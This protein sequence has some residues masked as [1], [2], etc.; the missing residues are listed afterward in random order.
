MANEQ[1]MWEPTTPGRRIFAQRTVLRKLTL[2]EAVA[3]IREQGALIDAG[4]LSK[5][6][7]DKERPNIYQAVA[8]AKFY[9]VRLND[10]G[11]SLSRDYP[12]A[13]SFLKADTQELLRQSGWSRNP[14]SDLLVSGV[15]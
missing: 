12:Q 11:F 3:G 6:E 14:A 9:G 2:K 13:L 4:K 10:L 15:A 8:I 7:N 1:G 5:I